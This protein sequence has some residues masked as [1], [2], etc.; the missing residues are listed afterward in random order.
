MK[1]PLSFGIRKPPQPVRHSPRRVCRREASGGLSEVP[2]KE[3]FI[4]APKDGQY[5]KEEEKINYDKNYAD[6]A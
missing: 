3:N 5:E 6:S 2:M 4:C 1:E